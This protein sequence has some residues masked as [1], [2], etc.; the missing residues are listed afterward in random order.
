M[1]SYL[2]GAGIIYIIIR[3]FEPIWYYIEGGIKAER[4]YGDRRREREKEISELEARVNK[5]PIPDKLK[6]KKHVKSGERHAIE[7]YR[8]HPN[9]KYSPNN[10]Y[11]K[12]WRK[13]GIDV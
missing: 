9:H 7:F 4:L 1:I 5:Q 12:K 3:L 10:K 6:Q 13:E 2:I 11:I 8:N